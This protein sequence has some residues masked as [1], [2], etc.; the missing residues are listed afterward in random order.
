MK[1]FF[2]GMSTLQ[3]T[4]WIIALLGSA[5]FLIIFILTFIGG[6]DSDM[7]ADAT[8]WCWFSVLHF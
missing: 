8:E 2:E 7:E 4:Y 6:G 3:Q 5:V 1:E